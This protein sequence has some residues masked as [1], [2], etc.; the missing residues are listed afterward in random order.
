MAENV[1]PLSVESMNS[2]IFDDDIEIPLKWWVSAVDDVN[3]TNWAT[4][5][6]FYGCPCGLIQGNLKVVMYTMMVI[7]RQ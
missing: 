3:M 1:T 5:T 2:R 6:G 4:P 7:I